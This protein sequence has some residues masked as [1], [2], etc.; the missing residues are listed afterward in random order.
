MNSVSGYRRDHDEP[1]PLNM[2]AIGEVLA[3]AIAGLVWIE[4]PKCR[5]ARLKN[6][7]CDC[8]GR[9]MAGGMQAKEHGCRG[10]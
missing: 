3:A 9:R 4:C 8:C 2:T 10:A 6:H 5:H 1:E 7:A